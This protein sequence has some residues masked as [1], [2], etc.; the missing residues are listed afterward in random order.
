[1]FVGV[2]D[3]PKGDVGVGTYLHGIVKAG[4]RVIHLYMVPQFTMEEMDMFD[5][6]RNRGVR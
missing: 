2:S 6:G 4:F 1:M 5:G 3:A